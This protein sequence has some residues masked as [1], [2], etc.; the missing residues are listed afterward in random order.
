MLTTSCE[1]RVRLPCRKTSDLALKTPPAAPGQRIGLIGGSFNPPHEGHL[2]VTQTAL[3]RLHLD[4]MWWLVSPGNPLKSNDALPDLS[5]RISAC[6]TLTQDYRRIDVSGL[7]QDLGSVYTAHTLAF[8]TRRFPLVH[9]VWVM[10]AD[11]LAGFHLWRQWRDIAMTVPIAV[12][13]RPGWHLAALSSP[14]ARALAQ[15]RL[16]S[17]RARILPFTKPPA[18]IFLSTRLSPHSSTALRRAKPI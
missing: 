11:N 7:E 6:R 4:R 15:H 13:D 5:E 16:P 14:V 1:N 9:F 2:M 10:G 18:W 12:I 3:K 8:L 17:S